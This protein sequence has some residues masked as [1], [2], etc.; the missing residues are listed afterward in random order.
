MGSRLSAT[1]LL[2]A[3]CATATA[4]NP[5]TVAESSGFEA[6]S[7]HADVMAFIRELQRGSDKI[8]VES[9]ATTT[10]PMPNRIRQR[11]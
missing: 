10:E 1:T 3:L 6:T 8:R 4:Q 11:M 7:R 2:A 5:Q 9:L